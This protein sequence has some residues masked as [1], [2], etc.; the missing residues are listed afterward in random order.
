L[1]VFKILGFACWLLGGSLASAQ[2]EVF[3][4]DELK[5]VISFGSS[6]QMAFDKVDRRRKIGRISSDPLVYQLTLLN[7]ADVFYAQSKFDRALAQYQKAMVGL[8]FPQSNEK[9]AHTPIS[10]FSLSGM[11]DHRFTYAEGL[12]KQAEQ[13]TLSRDNWLMM[14]RA[15]TGIAT[16]YHQIGNIRVAEKFYLKSLQIRGEQ[17]GKTS[18]YYVASLHNLAVLRTDQGRY[19]AAEDML[20]YVVRYFEK[21]R[22]KSSYQYALA[23]NNQAMLYAALGRMKEA[24]DLLAGIVLN[25]Q[26]SFPSHSLDPA[27]LLTNKALIEIE[28]EQYVA[29][30]KYLNEA[31]NMY[32][33]KELTKHADYHQI[34]LHLSQVY[35]L[36]GKFAFLSEFID[37]TLKEIGKDIGTDNMPYTYALEVKAEYFLA[38]LDYESAIGLFR[39]IAKQRLSKLGEL[40]KDYL[41]IINRIAICQ[42]QSGDNL[43]AYESFKKATNGYLQV[44]DKYFYNMSEKE[45]TRFWQVLKPELDVFYSFAV[46]Q[47]DLIPALLPLTYDL[48]IKTKGLLLHNAN[49]VRNA[50]YEQSNDALIVQYEAWLSNKEVLAGYYSMDKKTLTALGVNLTQLESES[51]ELEKA[52]NRSV[53]GGL[54]VT[55]NH[56]LTYRDVAGTLN[57]HQVAIEIMRI[58][59][60]FGVSIHSDQYVALLLTKNQQPKMV[61]I[62]EAHELE[63]KMAVYY[64]NAVKNRID[65]SLTYQKFWSPIQGALGDANEVFV[66]LDGIYNAININSLRNENNQFLLDLLTIDILPNTKVLAKGDRLKTQNKAYVLIG[67]PDFA[68][69]T[70]TP[71]PGTAKELKAIQELL[72]NADT[73]VLSAAMATEEGIK[74]IDNPKV[75]H[76]AT[77]GFFLGAQANTNSIAVTRSIGRSNPLMR[78]GLL[79]TG[80]GKPPSNEL[81][82]R[83]SDGILTAYEAMNLKLQN[84]DLVILSACETGSGEVVNGE[85]VYGL[86]R[87]FTIAGAK[88]LIMSLWKVDDQATM[89]LMTLFY[90]EWLQNGDLKGAFVKAQKQLKIKFKDPYYWASFVMVSN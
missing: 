12:L 68:N 27:R 10:V 54:Q 14:A 83:M 4:A 64:K 81:K 77:H 87:A 29:A 50:I 79:M 88:H 71:L 80:A 22:T 13:A 17:A 40:H 36:Q 33:E 53:L 76:I 56:E 75:L 70:I 35:L 73:K 20:K 61:V 24:G 60:Q 72:G 6:V 30:A 39:Q 84:T 1:K 16:Y 78:S 25:G 90:K 48:R 58:H 66:S 37:E 18:E 32:V 9:Q 74:E 41:R 5:L 63:S 11:Q 21:K 45:K 7:N 85:G 69:T 38:T 34:R 46:H 57:D 28:N 52:L 19:H 23:I 47:H 65:E 82:E 55:Q 89:E 3:R 43:G 2:S 51:N 62:G 86:S 49:Q 44:V 67:N 26:V 15:M 59:H 31:L 8:M 42:W